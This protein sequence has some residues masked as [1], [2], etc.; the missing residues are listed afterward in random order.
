[1]LRVGRVSERHHLLLS[2]CS[3]RQDAHEGQETMQNIIMYVHKCIRIHV[4]PWG[5]GG[6][7]NYRLH[8]LTAGDS[9]L[10]T[11]PHTTA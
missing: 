11:V 7:Q 8:S 5:G 2:E 3:M 4:Q 10:A 6:H 1:M 9:T